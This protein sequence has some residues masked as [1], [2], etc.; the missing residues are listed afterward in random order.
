VRS[1]HSGTAWRL[2]LDAVAAEVVEAFRARGVRV[3]LFK[4]PVLERWLYDDAG[5][6]AYRDIDLLV[7]PDAFD[8]AERTLAEL[9]FHMPLAGA[10][11]EERSWLEDEWRRG[12]FWVDLHRSLWGVGVDAETVWQTLSERTQPMEIGGARVEVP[13]EPVQALIAALHAAHHGRANPPPL[14]DLG[15]AIARG[16]PGLWR[17]AADIAQRLNA[18]GAFTLGLGILPAGE[19]LVGRLGLE[20]SASV[21]VHLKAQGA[22]RL[23]LGV[24]RFGAAPNLGSRLALLA[25]ALVPSPPALRDLYPLAR[26]GRLGLLAAYAWRPLS[27]C[28]HAPGALREIKSARRRAR[29]G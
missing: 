9:G 18:L 5:R 16:E 10:R 3:L 28:V 12:P 26:R 4:G 21:Q 25:S 17:T 27:L 6:R 14:E 2:G 11:P 13:T 24:V 23:S 29:A 19:E 8:V 22:S 1:K 15:R 20:M 7:A